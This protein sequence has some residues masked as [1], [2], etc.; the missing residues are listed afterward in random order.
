MKVKLRKFRSSD[1]LKDGLLPALRS[2]GCKNQGWLARSGWFTYPD[3]GD[4]QIMVLRL[5]NLNNSN[6]RVNEQ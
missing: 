3:I 6:N 4:V 5:V 1:P 2:E